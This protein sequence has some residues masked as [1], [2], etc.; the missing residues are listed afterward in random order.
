MRARAEMHRAE[1]VSDLQRAS[2]AKISSTASTSASS[3]STQKSSPRA[4]PKHRA[5]DAPLPPFSEDSDLGAVVGA[6]AELVVCGR[7]KEV[8]AGGELGT[9]V[10]HWDGGAP[11]H[12]QLMSRAKVRIVKSDPH[13]ASCSSPPG[14]TAMPND[15]MAVGSSRISVG[16]G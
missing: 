4:W 13:T 8:L 1:P 10:R 2:R 3:R 9:V 6:A 5:A 15:R 16:K 7:V 14:M 12:P 11:A